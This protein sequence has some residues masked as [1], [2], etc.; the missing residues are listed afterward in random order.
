MQYHVR[1]YAS[2]VAGTSYGEDVSFT[3]LPSITGTTTPTTNA[4]TGGN[5][6]ITGTADWVNPDYITAD[7]TSYASASLSGSVLSSGYLEGTNYEFAIPAE[8][9]INGIVVT[10]GRHESGIRSDYIDVRDSTVKLLKAGVLTGSNKAATGTEWPTAV[11]TPAIYGT[12]ADLWG[13][14]W[15]PAE[16]N[17]NNF[18][19]ALSVISGV[20]RI[21]YVDYMQISITYTV[22]MVGSNTTV[23]CGAGTPIVTY[24]SGITCV[25]TVM[26]GSGDKTPTGNVSWT[27][28]GSGSF[29]NSPCALSGSNGTATCSVTYTPSSVG[30]GSHLL[31]ATY[32][33]DPN[34][35]TSNGNQT[36]TVNK[37]VA[38]VT[39]GSLTQTYDGTPK[40]ATATTVPA[41]LTVGF[42]YD[43][44]ATAPINIGSYAVTAT[45]TDLNYTGTA[46]GTLVIL[47]ATHSIPLTVGWN[48]VSFNVH[49]TNTDIATVLSSI[50]GNY[51]LVYAWDAT[52]SSNNWLMYDP[53][54]PPFLNSLNHL[55]ETMGFWIYMT[56]ADTL[57][58]TGL[59]PVTT[60]IN[61]YA[62]AGGWNLVAYP[63]GVNRP[64]PEALSDNGIGTDFSLVYAYDA[65]DA[66]PWK[67][68]DVNMPPF[69]N[70]L[71][72][73]SPSWGYWVKVNAN[74][75]WSV[76]YLAE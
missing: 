37:A 25:A 36:V 30:S 19:V 76:D 65:D 14:T 15:T 64:L 67:L 58:V 72:E 27:T 12:T 49:P 17:A 52:S 46:N 42:T 63:S 48:L 3:T 56:T 24:G 23:S 73:L 31:T 60:N 41:G 70:S 54:M 28:N 4:R 13:T 22:T 69:L 40:L 59:I 47:P 57:E 62:N 45:V 53:S 68:F 43:G 9:V 6:T 16:I 18:G 10:V 33:G 2:N 35:F 66:A 74:H 55:D 50:T 44:S 21:A 39:L 29:V 61:V 7:D 51:S 34:F 32:A 38:I 71:T 11:A 1:A 20:N 26:R 8:A 5:V 75:T